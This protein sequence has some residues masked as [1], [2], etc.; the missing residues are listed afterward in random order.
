MNK[1]GIAAK[2]CVAKREMIQDLVAGLRLRYGFKWN[3]GPGIA[4]L[5]N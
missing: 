2:W 1:T 5:N 4:R 3:P